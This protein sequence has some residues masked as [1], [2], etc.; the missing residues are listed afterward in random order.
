MNKIC[1]RVSLNQAI[2]KFNSNPL[3]GNLNTAELEQI[4]AF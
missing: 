4:Q 2:E 3:D 1:E